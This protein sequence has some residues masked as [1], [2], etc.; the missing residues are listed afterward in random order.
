[1]N[2]TIAVTSQKEPFPCCVCKEQI[3]SY[4]LFIT[5]GCHKDCIDSLAVKGKELKMTKVRCKMKCEVTSKCA[6]G[7]YSVRMCAITE[8]NTE[9]EQFYAGALS[10]QLGLAGIRQQ[11]FEPGEEYYVDIVKADAH[12]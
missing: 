4:E 8:G 1:M 9:N 5:L 3:K 7:T 6:D 11:W 12:N 2:N 10:G